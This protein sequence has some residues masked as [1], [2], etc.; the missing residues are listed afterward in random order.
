VIT[1][2][3]MRVMLALPTLLLAGPAFAHTGEGGADGFFV[4]F[5]WCSRCGSRDRSHVR[6]RSR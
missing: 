1:L 6:L 5:T 4:G 2:L 3:F